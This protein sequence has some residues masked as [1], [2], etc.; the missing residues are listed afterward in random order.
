M[1]V[2]ILITLAAFAAL[3][4]TACGSTAPRENTVSPA[5]SAEE[6]AE[7]L[8]DA[9]RRGDAE[10][11][12]SCFAGETETKRVYR[13]H[14]RGMR[15]LTWAEFTRDFS[16]EW[17]APAL[18]PAEVWTQVDARTEGGLSVL[19]YR[20]GS[21]DRPDRGLVEIAACPVGTGWLVAW[22]AAPR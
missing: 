9:R 14:R 2:R 20:Q 16:M 6:I 7:R 18:A 8:L 12:W 1:N 4:L 10:D 11:A 5:G 15:G 21:D 22:V 17:A 13:D 3:V 19:V